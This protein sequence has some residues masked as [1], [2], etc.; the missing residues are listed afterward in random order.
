MMPG[1]CWNA[2]DLSDC[3]VNQRWHRGKAE[4][5]WNQSVYRNERV[6]DTPHQ[7]C[8]DLFEMVDCKQDMAT[9]LCEMIRSRRLV[10]RFVGFE[11]FV[12]H[13]YTLAVV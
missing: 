10:F 11:T 13:G 5:A 9:R 12:E 2:S 4:T 3:L 7:Q 6:F 8:P 1:E